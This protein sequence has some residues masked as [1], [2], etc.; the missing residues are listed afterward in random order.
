M[1]GCA[2]PR[3]SK[4][5]RLKWMSEEQKEHQQQ[6]CSTHWLDLDLKPYTADTDLI[7]LFPLVAA[8]MFSRMAVEEITLDRPFLFLI[9]HKHTGNTPYNFNKKSHF[10][11]QQTN[12]QIWLF[13]IFR[14]RSVRRSV[15]PPSETI[16]HWRSFISCVWLLLLTQ[17]THT[18]ND[19]KS[20][21]TVCVCWLHP[22]TTADTEILLDIVEKK[23]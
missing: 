22:D 6:V 3:S 11:G 8:I 9:Q 2:S 21:M 16:T 23:M 18:R 15:Q 20:H 17:W 19:T 1:K 12:F 4:E 14:C 7:P 10:T 13:F 5:L